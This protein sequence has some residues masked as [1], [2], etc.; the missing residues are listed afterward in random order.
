MHRGSQF[1]KPVVNEGPLTH[2]MIFSHFLCEN[3]AFRAF[4]SSLSFL[5]FLYS[6]TLDVSPVLFLFSLVPQE[7][8]TYAIVER[9]GETADL[10]A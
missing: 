2:Q 7:G 4:L 5:F 1:V 6:S 8:L 9:N 10:L 3:T